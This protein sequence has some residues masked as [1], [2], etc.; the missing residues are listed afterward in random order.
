MTLGRFAIILCILG[1]FIQAQF[2]DIEREIVT[3]NI[4]R[5]EIFARKGHIF[6]NPALATY[7]RQFEW[8]QPTENVVELSTLEKEKAQLLTQNEEAAYKRISSVLPKLFD[9][10]EDAPVEYYSTA[11]K[12]EIQKG[13]L[14]SQ[15]DKATKDIP[16]RSADIFVTSINLQTRENTSAFKKKIKKALADQIDSISYFKV[17]RSKDGQ[18]LRLEDCYADS[19]NQEHCA[20]EFILK[21]NEVLY[22]THAVNQTTYDQHWYFVYNERKLFLGRFYFR[23]MGKVTHDYRFYF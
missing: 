3:A 6:K 5:N 16:Y 18:F 1:L 9:L 19:I 2:Q 4:G 21:G 10:R 7:F 17:Q 11:N 8:Y 23:Q 13:E 20:T 15:I 22:V 14:R 12:V